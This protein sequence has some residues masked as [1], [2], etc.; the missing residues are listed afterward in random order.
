MTS[1]HSMELPR[2]VIVG[3]NI[4]E[5][6]G[7]LCKELGFSNGALVL[8]GTHTSKIAG[9]KVIDSLKSSGFEVNNFTVQEPTLKNVRR[10]EEIIEES[11]PE[12]VLGVGGGKVIDVAKY[13]ASEKKIQYISVPTAA[14]HDGISSPQA[15]LK[16]LGRS[17]SVKATAPMAILA[18]LYIIVR[19]PYRLVASGCGDIISKYT[20]VRDWWLSHKLKNVYYGDYA[21]NLALMSA[22]IISKST[23]IIREKSEDGIR[24]VVEALISCGVATSIAGSSKPCSG[25]EHLFSHSLNQVASKPALHGEQC[26]VGTI[27]MAY[28]HKMNWK[29]IREVL[30]KIGAPTTANEL[31][32]DTE[33]VVE[34]LTQAH[35]VRPERYT[36]LGE[37]GL[38]RDRAVRLAKVTGVIT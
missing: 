32:V 4:I 10:V 33:E 27:M 5:T 6:V 9:G 15:S 17:F 7:T 14:S 22:K 26:G 35:K 34:A 8:A 24:I 18:D 29:R 21:A 11:K 23:P 28:L 13:S 20:S 12:I 25:S 37:K 31:K 16:N 1:I 36:I 2:R 19:S 38:S 30:K 3:R